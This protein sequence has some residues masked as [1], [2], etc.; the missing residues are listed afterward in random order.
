MKRTLEKIRSGAVSRNATMKCT[1]QH[2]SITE[3]DDIEGYEELAQN[4]LHDV[5]AVVDRIVLV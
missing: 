1:F 5:L 4:E 3:L 2:G